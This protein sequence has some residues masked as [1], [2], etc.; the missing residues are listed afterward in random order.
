MKHKYMQGLTLVEVLISIAILGILTSIAVPN[1]SDLLKDARLSS[2]TDLLV[3]SLAAAR[4]EA[5]EGSK[6]VSVCPV[7]NANT[8]TACSANVADWSNGWIY[9]Y[10]DSGGNL[11]VLKRFQGKKDLT[12]TSTATNVNFNKTIGNSTTAES[13]QLCISGRKAEAVNVS[14]PGRI[15]KKITTTVCS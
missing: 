2:Q 10:L 5:V 13:F 9:Y 11:V 6:Q 1:M 7:V 3:S 15:S 14:L 4:L 8:A 12:I